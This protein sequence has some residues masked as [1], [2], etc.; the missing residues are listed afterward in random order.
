MGEMVKDSEEKPKMVS[1]LPGTTLES[2]T[3]EMALKLL[4]LPRTVGV[5][6]ESGVEITAQLGRYGAYVKCGAE[7]RSLPTEI[8]VLDVN[9]EQSLELLKQPPRRGRQS[10]PKLPLKVVGKHPESGAEIVVKSGQYGPYVTDGT[11]NASLPRGQEVGTLTL[12]I[13]LDLLKARAEKIASGEVRPKRGGK[14]R[15]ARGAGAGKKAEAGGKAK[16]TK[17]KKTAE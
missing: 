16:K 17:P 11:V 7:S 5:H 10:A 1:L 14:A 8:S 15:G 13:S 2:V 4:E 3:P 9:L 12:E 6:P